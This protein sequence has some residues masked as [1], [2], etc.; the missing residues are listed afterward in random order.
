MRAIGENVGV[1]IFKTAIAIS[2]KYEFLEDP[3]YTEQFGHGPRP[4]PLGRPTR[5]ACGGHSRAGPLGPSDRPIGG[6]ACHYT[7]SVLW[8]WGFH[9]LEFKKNRLCRFREKWPSS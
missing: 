3:G 6:G 4:P 8:V 5:G 7:H 2:K 1:D 9:F